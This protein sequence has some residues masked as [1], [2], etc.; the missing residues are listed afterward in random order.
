MKVT[1][2]HGRHVTCVWMTA[3]LRMGPGSYC[4]SWVQSSALS[5][6]HRGMIIPVH[7]G[8]GRD[9]L[10][11]ILVT[12]N[13]IILVWL[14]SLFLDQTAVHKCTSTWFSIL[15][16]STPILNS[17]IS[18]YGICIQTFAS[19]EIFSHLSRWAYVAS[20]LWSYST[21]SN[22]SLSNWCTA[23][24]IENA[25]SSHTVVEFDANWC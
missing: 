7:K 23:N 16:F 4:A 17:S 14:E 9:P 19:F 8:K 22:L 5:R 12:Q 2:Q 3:L 24:A 1:W 15:K 18:I 6:S 25:H 11:C 10:I 20:W 13:V 21:A